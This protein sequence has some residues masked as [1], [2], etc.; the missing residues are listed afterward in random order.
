M[1][2]ILL[3][4]ELVDRYYIQPRLKQKMV[5]DLFDKDTSD[6]KGME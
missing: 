5:F 4:Y 1:A 2:A 6:K 3:I